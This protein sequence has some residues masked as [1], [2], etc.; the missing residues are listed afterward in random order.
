MS[1]EVELSLNK[2]LLAGRTIEEHG[3]YVTVTYPRNLCSKNA[4]WQHLLRHPPEGVGRSRRGRGRDNP[5]EKCH[6]N[7]WA[8]SAPIHGAAL[9]R[10]MADAMADRLP[11][12]EST[13]PGPLPEELK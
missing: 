1:E 13:P 4:A 12:R 5:W 10:G 9:A 8:W 6:F 2:K 3:G 7:G 11:S